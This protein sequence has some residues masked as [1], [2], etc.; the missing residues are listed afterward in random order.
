MKLNFGYK[1][2]MADEKQPSSSRD[3]A[4]LSSISSMLSDLEQRVLSIANTWHEVERDDVSSHL[5]DVERSLRSS[6]RR[7]DRAI[8]AMGF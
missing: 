7:L 8:T 5:Y 4:E 3:A 1:S 6:G 2:C